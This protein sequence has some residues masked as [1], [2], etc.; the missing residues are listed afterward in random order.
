MNATALTIGKGK[1]KAQSISEGAALSLSAI[2]DELSSVLA[3][4][5]MP[6]MADCVVQV[7]DAWKPSNLY[8]FCDKATAKVLFLIV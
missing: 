2:S 4:G 5:E 1:G 8:I 3:D 7:T 6:N